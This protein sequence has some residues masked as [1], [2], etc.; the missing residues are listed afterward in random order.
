WCGGGVVGGGSGGGRR[1]GEWDAARLEARDVGL[2]GGVAAL[3][4]PTEVAVEEAHSAHQPLERG[5]PLGAP[6]RE[7]AQ[8]TGQPADPGLDAQV[9]ALDHHAAD[10][11]R[12]R[13]LPAPVQRVAEVAERDLDRVDDLLARE[14]A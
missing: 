6:R 2:R 10:L 14:E 1:G 13:A 8:L 9:L 5:A 7:L 4:A 3:V 12:S 11:L